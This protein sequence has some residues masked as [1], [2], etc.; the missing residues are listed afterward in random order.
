[1]SYYDRRGNPIDPWGWVELAKDDTY[2]RVALTALTEDIEVSTVWLGLDHGF[3]R[4]GPPLIFETMIFTRLDEPTVLWGITLTHDGGET[5]RW[6]TEEAA[7]AGH[8]RIVAELRSNIAVPT[9][10]KENQRER[11]RG[12]PPGDTGGD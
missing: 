4:P 3:G 1:M 9:Q 11:S 5:W 2:R 8:D 12:H 7:L 6:P 10:E